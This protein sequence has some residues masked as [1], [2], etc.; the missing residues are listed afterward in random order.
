M[1]IDIL[2]A[3]ETREDVNSALNNVVYSISPFSGGLRI[4]IVNYSFMI[5][6]IF[7]VQHILKSL[8]CKIEIIEDEEP[9]FAETLWDITNKIP[10]VAFY[11]AYHGIR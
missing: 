8:L 10:Y 4:I 5:A 2:P 7:G 1:F 9:R 6:R 11:N 3:S